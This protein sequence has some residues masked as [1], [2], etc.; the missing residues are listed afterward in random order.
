MW[1]GGSEQHF[2][3]PLPWDRRDQ[4][5]Q[6]ANTKKL[7]HD[8]RFVNLT[9]FSVKDVPFSI[10]WSLWRRG[11]PKRAKWNPRAAQRDS[12]AVHQ[13]LPKETIWNP[14]WVQGTQRRPKDT[15]RKPKGKIYIKNSRSTAPADV[16]LYPLSDPCT[17]S[18]LPQTA[19]GCRHCSQRG[20]R[21]KVL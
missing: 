10:K 21:Q 15:P 2:M 20:G 11:S 1:K 9:H 7:K 16:M 6:R 14:K 19:R 12:K 3:T 8:Y 18:A 13:V 5:D 4:R 17:N